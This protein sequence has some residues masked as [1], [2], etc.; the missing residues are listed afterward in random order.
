MLDAAIAVARFLQFASAAILFGSSLFVFYGL[1]QSRG[2]FGFLRRALFAAAGV[3]L[4]SNIGAIML[5]AE[6]FGGEA[7][8]AVDADI[9]RS[10]LTETSFGKVLILRVVL[11]V[12]ALT[13]C[14]VFA[15]QHL[16]TVVLGTALLASYAW[17]G[18]AA[19]EEGAASVTH[20]TSDVLHLLA[21]GVWIGALVPLMGLLRHEA[22]TGDAE[23][24]LYGL[25]RFSGIGV[26]VVAVL[27]LSGVVN[28]WF[29]IGPAHVLEIFTTAYGLLLLLKLALF[30]G[31]LVLAAANRFRLVPD[32]EAQLA[33]GGS[34]ASALAAL[35]NSL[36][37][38]NALAVLVLLA[39]GLLGMLEPPISLG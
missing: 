12:C 36:L 27:V 19:A 38:E 3:A 35:R 20:A 4:V 10:L 33:Q 6:S 5:Q 8:N 26:A 39:V 1:K 16:A 29:V 31:M 14:F 32:L 28:S 23:N 37:A 18:H 11:A 30:A 2:D 15:R 21:A 34:P 17:T 22:Q 13:A 7:R 24:A 25:M 9:L